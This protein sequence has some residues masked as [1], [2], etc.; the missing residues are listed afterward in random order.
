MFSILIDN[1]DE[2]LAR[3]ATPARWHNLGNEA[4]GD[5]IL[6]GCDTLAGGTWF[7]VTRAGSFAALTNFTEPASVR[8]ATNSTRSRGELVSRFLHTYATRAPT[9]ADLTTFLDEAGDEKSA[10][11][12]FNL[13]VGTA[14]RDAA[15]LGYLTNRGEDPYSGTVLASDTHAVVHGLSNST[16]ATPWPKIGDAQ[17]LIRDVLKRT[18]SVDALID[19]LFGVLDTSRGP[20]SEPDEMRRTIRVEPVRL[21][22]NADGTQL[23]APGASG[24]GVVYRGWYGTRTATVLLVPRSAAHPAV[25]VERDVYTL[26]ADGGTSD[27]PPTHLDFGDVRVRAAHER[28][29]TWTL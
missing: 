7:G 1:R 16:L 13:V 27:T 9:E 23:A 2:F 20:I 11:N 18:T 15:L 6:C 26:H 29:Y 24:A 25:L 8:A 21:P 28:R 19:G 14:R 3:P 4:V 17:A 10:F 12:G 22:S 5:A